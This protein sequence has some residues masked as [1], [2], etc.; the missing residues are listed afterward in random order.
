[1]T[2][3][4]PHNEITYSF[5]IIGVHGPSGCLRVRAARG[6]RGR[7]QTDRRG[8]RQSQ[9]DNANGVDITPDPQAANHCP[10]MEAAAHVTSL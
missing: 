1:M 4:L 5:N 9:A 6:S 3:R 10:M 8:N 2:S 7:A